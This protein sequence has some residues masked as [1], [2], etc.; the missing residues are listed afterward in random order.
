MKKITMLY[1]LTVMTVMIFALVACDDEGSDKSSS[2]VTDVYVAGTLDKSGTYT[3]TLWVNGDDVS[4]SST[5]NMSS[6]NAVFV[7]G[8]NVYTGGFELSGSEIPRCWM[9]GAA[10]SLSGYTGNSRIG[11]VF[12]G[13]GSI[14][15]SGFDLT[16]AVYWTDGSITSLDDGSNSGSGNAVFVSGTNVF[17]AGS[18]QL[19]AVYWMNY[20]TGK[21][22]LTSAA[23][24]AAANDISVSGDDVYI[25]G[26]IWDTTMGPDYFAVY[27]KHSLNNWAADAEQILLTDGEHKSEATSI[28]VSGNDIYIAGYEF[29][30]TIGIQHRRAKYWKQAMSSPVMQETT[31]TDG[32]YDAYAYSIFVSG[33]D[34]YVAGRE[35][36]GTGGQSVAKYWKNGEPV[37]LSDGT[38]YATASSI[39][40]YVH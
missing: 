38:S 20:A 36:D 30:N 9:N 21:K 40:V 7:A 23:N 22:A 8:S 32:T 27:W 19:Q 16:G 26:H 31:L 39:F 13:N 34:V 6:A 10:I 33:D 12:F 17:V 1:V 5:T 29:D 15:A 24:E 18:E 37:V 3:A 35:L 11:S 28:F 25:T 4:V 14:Y 2:S